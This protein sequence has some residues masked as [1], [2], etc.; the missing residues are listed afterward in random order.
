MNAVWRLGACT[1]PA[2][3][4]AAERVV[5]RLAGA[6]CL[7]WVE[8]AD[9]HCPDARRTCL[10]EALAEDRVDV[11]VM[12]LVDVPAPPPARVHVACVPRRAPPAD[13][14]F[15]RSQASDRDI[16]AAAHVATDHAWRVSGLRALPQPPTAV[17]THR[18]AAAALAA[19]VEGEADVALLAADAAEGLALSVRAVPAGEA[20]LPRAGQGAQALLVRVDDARAA[21]AVE[22]CGDVETAASVTAERAVLERLGL[23]PAAAVGARATLAHGVLRLDVGYDP[24]DGAPPRRVRVEGALTAAAALGARAAEALRA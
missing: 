19:V 12:P 8:P 14:W 21:E 7:A 1:T 10:I 6:W 4:A 24:G 20:F 23:T 9:A 13:A 15:V 5:E 2:A 3:R 16:P 22:S 17:T 18:D 11:V